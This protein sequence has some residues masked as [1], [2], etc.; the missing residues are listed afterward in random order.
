MKTNIIL[1]YSSLLISPL[2]SSC[3][4]S[5]KTIFVASQEIDCTETTT[6]KCLQIRESSSQEW[7]HFN[8][9]IKD[10]DYQKGYTYQLKV[11]VTSLKGQQ[12]NASYT[13]V[14]VLAKE[15]A[16]DN[17]KTA[18]TD[19]QKVVY[20]GQTRGYFLRIEVTEKQIDVYKVYGATTPT[21]QAITVKEWKAIVEAV[22]ALELSTIHTLAS[23]SHDRTRDA[24]IA[25]QIIIITSKGQFKSSTFDHK[26]P[27]SALTTLASQILSITEGINE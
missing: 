8:G 24:A 23:P 7:E 22:E 19:I 27:P 15:K 18:V 13:L 16:E 10:F 14:E 25:A 17:K 21:T 2:W 3:G 20:E 11:Q 5:Y 26:N 6:Q 12:Q 4:K 9:T 1:I